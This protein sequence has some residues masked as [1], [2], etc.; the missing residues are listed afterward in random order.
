MRQSVS[1][2]SSKKALPY[3]DSLVEIPSSFKKM[4]IKQSDKAA[5]IR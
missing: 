2:E 4:Y 3:N 5:G 1:V